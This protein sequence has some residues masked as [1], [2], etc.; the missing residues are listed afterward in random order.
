MKKYTFPVSH[1][2]EEKF[3]HKWKHL[4]NAWPSVPAGWT[5][6]VMNALPKL[7]PLLWRHWWIP[8]FVKRWIRWS[9]CGF[10][11]VRIKYWWAYDLFEHKWH[12]TRGSISQIKEKF[13]TLRIYMSGYNDEI[14]AIIKEAEDECSETCQRCASTYKAELC[15]TGPYG[16]MM[17]LC[18]VCQGIEVAKPMREWDKEDGDD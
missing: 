2:Q 10:S 15:S 8:R 1:K 3:Y 6:I 9:T 11:I 16:W 14:D 7:E 18:P 13:G 17:V 5:H 12:L 4:G